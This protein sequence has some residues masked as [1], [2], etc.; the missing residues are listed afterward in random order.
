M[1]ACFNTSKTLADIQRYIA[2]TVEMSFFKV[3][4][5]NLKNLLFI[6]EKEEEEDN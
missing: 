4:M 3:L 1:W 5:N 2:E 6:G